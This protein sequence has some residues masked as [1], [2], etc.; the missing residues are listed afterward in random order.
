MK[1][2]N[3]TKKALVSS[4]L[5]L[6]LSSSMLV[7]TTFA[8]FTDSVTS[9][10]NVIQT[11]TLNVGM[12]WAEGSK[13]VP[14]DDSTDWKDA[15]KGAI[16]DYTNWEPGY[17][18]ARHLR[19]ANEGSLALKYQ[20]AIVPNG[21]V[22]ELANVIDV[23]YFET[24]A[25]LNRNTLTA[26][27]KLGTLAQVI[28]KA[29]A[30][31]IS[32]KVSGNLESGK[33]KEITI[34]FKMQ[35]SAGNEYQNMSLGAD[36]SVQLVATQLAYEKDSFGPD[37]DKDIVND[38]G[39]LY[40]IV[41]GELTLIEVTDDFI[42]T[43]LN[44][45]NGCTTIGYGAFDG[46][47]TLDTIV[48]PS[49]VKTVDD[50]AFSQSNI[51][52]V[53]LNEGLETI[54]NRAFQ[55]MSSLTEITLP[56]TLKTIEQ[57]AF[58]G[59]NLTS[60]SVPESVE[61]IAQGAFAYNTQ[62]KSITIY[63]S[64][65]IGDGTGT[66]NPTLNYVARACPNLETVYIFGEP[67]YVTGGMTFCNTE[68]AKTDK[69]TFYVTSDDAKTALEQAS[70]SSMAC[71]PSMNIKI[72]NLPQATS[73][74]VDMMAQGGEIVLTENLMLDADQTATVAKGVSTVLD[75]N[76]YEIVSE[77]DATG[78]N[79]NLFDV[80]GN[81][82]IK[83]GTIKTSHSGV[84][85]GW[86][87]STNVANVTDS[88]VLNIENAT[89]ENLGGSDMAFG[90]HLNN[91]GEVTLNVTNSTIKAT[92]VAVRAF[93]SG[94]N[95]NNITVENSTLHGDNHAF[96][97]HNYT[98]ADF[99]N[100][101]TKTATQQALLNLDIVNNGNTLTNSSTKPVV[102]Y[103]F[104]NSLYKNAD[105]TPVI[106]AYTADELTNAFTSAVDGDTIWLM[107][108]ITG[109]A[110]FTQ[111]K[112]KTVSVIVDGRGHVY[113]GV[114]EVHGLSEYDKDE[115]L[116]IQNINFETDEALSKD[117]FIWSYAN[118]APE[119]YAHNITVDNCTFTATGSAEYV[120]VGV[121]FLQMYNL[122]VTNC[123]ATNLHSLVQAQSCNNTVSVEKV[124]LENCKNGMSF[125]NTATVVVK[126]A[127]IESVVDGGYGIRV[128]GH[129]DRTDGC[130]LTVENST[131][132]A[133]VPVLV[134]EITTGTK[135]DVTFSGNNTLTATNDNKYQVVVSGDDWDN[136][137]SLPVNPTGN[138]TLTGVDAFNVFTGTTA[139]A[140]VDALT[141]ALTEGGS[142]TLTSDV[143]LGSTALAVASG[144]DVTLDLN[145]KTITY[146]STDSKATCAIENKGTLTIKN[147][148]VTYEGVG[149]PNFGYGTNTINNSGK[150]VIDGA[151]VINTTNSGS[152]NAIDCAPGS[153]LVVN[154]GT[155]TSQKVTIRVRDN[156]NVTINGGT[157]TG[158]R[159]VQVHVFQNVQK[160]TKLTING[161]TLNGTELALYSYAYGNCTFA[162]TT[163]T[164]TGGEFNGDVAFGGGNKTAVETLSITGGVFN[165]EL[166][167]YLANDGWEEIAKP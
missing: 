140:T 60:L 162:L 156:A 37:Y 85:M 119:R 62:L 84:N 115:T 27:K 150:L 91:W 76:G 151:T 48:L 69:I 159:A 74:F 63:G 103:G 154:G 131:I 19:I 161:G 167:R 38:G 33:D 135:Y 82:T 21:T 105:W 78:A 81:L 88:G 160:E 31:S 121:K 109:N 89:I 157:I 104:T 148:T 110:T 100:D 165:G 45:M 32:A 152:S 107:N 35:E 39:V 70:A 155:I 13:A 23:Y 46:N 130:T 128:E 95:M 118:Q 96:W 75:L 15:S 102:R 133:F 57:Y 146:A 28:D 92:Y 124:T 97:V 61:T 47:T 36:F 114:M 117:A 111:P 153:T 68:S 52:N 44:V 26:D 126:K 56:S 122:N 137:A 10:G 87:N 14:A 142:I 144:K 125:G 65:A 134:R 113:N 164:I 79:R 141:S 16:F 93:N 147:G 8:W 67:T 101:E 139:V 1:K 18:Q 108:D 9:T 40:N 20:L 127:T 50:Y 5:A 59:T 22:S 163:I 94:P 29:N 2:K 86:N 83:N 106:L 132:N 51:S 66:N 42:G 49:S 24:A 6:T 123:T 77:S 12:Y 143:D 43:T 11:G 149:D 73:N 158:A 3:T 71:N 17:A 90:V 112:N 54:G 99:G 64:P 55:K 166:G 53:V 41:N 34:V 129:T 7:G 30:N 4:L 145:G 120:M 80:R 98:L 138:Y 25:Q 72:V 136:D 58:Q 116:L